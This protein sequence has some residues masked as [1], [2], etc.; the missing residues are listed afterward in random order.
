MSDDSSFGF[1]TIDQVQSGFRRLHG[2]I[3]RNRGRIEIRHEQGTC[4]LISKE[5]LETLEHALEILSNTSDVRK[6]AQIIE[7]LST[8]AARGPLA[9]ARR[10]AAN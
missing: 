10:I 2:Q 4:V 3:C 1:M 7:A 6:M 8:T 5:E 9:P